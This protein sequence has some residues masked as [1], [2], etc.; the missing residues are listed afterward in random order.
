MD[1]LAMHPTVKPTAMVADA[2]LDC[3]TRRGIV[4]DC[5]GGSGTTL[6]AA[7]KTSR[8]GYVMELDPAYVDVT[9]QRYQNLTGKVASHA[10]TGASFADT[11]AERGERSL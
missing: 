9:I 1:D 11:R 7:E 4:L 8:R 2:I 6:V 10:A 3:S 5:F